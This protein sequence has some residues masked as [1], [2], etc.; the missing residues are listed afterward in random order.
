MVCDSLRRDFINV[1]SFKET[2]F[3]F[4]TV[5]EVFCNFVNSEEVI[6]NF[7]YLL[8]LLLWGKKSILQLL[9]Y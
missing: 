7:F 2:I 5:K 8:T 1:L 9:K 4:A 3:N 6:C